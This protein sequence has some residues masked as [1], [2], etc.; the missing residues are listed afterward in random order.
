MELK[1]E[2]RGWFRIILSDS[3][4]FALD[5]LVRLGL[6]H[7]DEIRKHELAK[8]G[9]NNVCKRVLEAGTDFTDRSSV[10]LGIKKKRSG[11]RRRTNLSRSFSD[12]NREIENAKGS[13]GKI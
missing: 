8:R 7:S 11:K 10:A 6:S 3:E 4:L 2:M 12:F 9:T 13:D 5:T 1:S